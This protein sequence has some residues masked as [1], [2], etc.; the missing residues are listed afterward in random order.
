MWIRVTCSLYFRMEEST[1]LILMLRPRI[2]IRQWVARET[3]TLEPKVPVTSFTDIFG[4]HCQRLVAPR[5]EFRVETSADVMTTDTPEQIHY[6]Y[7]VEIPNLPESTLIY[8][9]PSRYC[10]SDRFNQMARE[11]V[12]D[13][14]P[15]YDQVIAIKDWIQRTIKYQPESSV[16]PE[17]AV[18]VN[19][20]G[21]G[22][23]RDLAHLGITL[24]RSISIPARM[25]VGYLYGLQPMD[26]HAWFEVFV[27]GNWHT[28]D[29]TQ[30][31]LRAGRVAI[32]YGRDAADVAVYTQ[33]GPPA[34]HTSIIVSVGLPEEDSIV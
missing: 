25:V 11:I 32:A 16:F 13:Q 31:D 7:F 17:S 29:P 26:L 15:G 22:V 4:N 18:E 19:Q 6:T 12:G 2:D 9:H 5:G 27:G 23:C 1:P 24:C 34:L 10:E 14:A 8:L 28:I 30:K 21:I 20:K 33:F 3:Y